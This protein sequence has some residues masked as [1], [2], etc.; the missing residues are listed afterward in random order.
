[1]TFRTTVV[2]VLKASEQCKP[3]RTLPISPSWFVSHAVQMRMTTV[4]VPQ[5][6][7]SSTVENVIRLVDR[8]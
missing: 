2:S 3:M 4:F 6:K 5:I 7:G 1:V 8:G